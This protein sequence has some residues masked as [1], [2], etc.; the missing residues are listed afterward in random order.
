[1]I[2]SVT[3]ESNRDS[4]Q[5]VLKYE[6]QTPSIPSELPSPKSIDQVRVKQTRA[7]WEK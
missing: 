2:R 7:R 5:P 4:A 6:P 1:M 3:E